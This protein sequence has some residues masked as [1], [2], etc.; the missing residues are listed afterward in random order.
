M[1]PI[2]F[3]KTNWKWIIDLSGKYKTIELLEDSIGEN[4]DDVQSGEEEAF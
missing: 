2:L 4:L 3:T 1:D